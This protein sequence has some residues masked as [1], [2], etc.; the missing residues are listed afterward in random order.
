MSLIL[1]V[2]RTAAAAPDHDDD[3]DDDVQGSCSGD[4]DDVHSESYPLISYKIRK[5][6]TCLGTLTTPLQNY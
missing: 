4:D 3:D 5:R 6:K 2:V 1:S